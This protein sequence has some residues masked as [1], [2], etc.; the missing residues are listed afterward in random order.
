M[1]VPFLSLQD[2]TAMHGDEIREAARRVIDNG[3]CKAKRMRRLNN[4]MPST[5]VR[6]MPSVV[7]MDWTR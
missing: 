1:Q 2:V 4:I 5:S 7:P 6:L 3:I